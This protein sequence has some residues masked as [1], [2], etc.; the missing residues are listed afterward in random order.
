MSHNPNIIDYKEIRRLCE[1]SSRI[2]ERVVDDFLLGFAA[3]HHGLEKKMNLAFSRYRHVS[4]K[5]EKETVNL[6][7][8][9]FIMHRVFSEGGLIGKFL[10]NPS[11]DRFM[12]EERSY[13]IQQAQ[14]PWRFSFAE[15]IEEPE[16]DFYR[17]KDVFSR[18]DYLLFS[19]SISDLKES[20]DAWLWF[21][22]IG[23][24]GS[25]WQSYGPIGA[26]Q[27]FEHEDIFFFAS[28]K[29]PDV[30]DES[31][32]QKDIENDPIAYMMLLSGAAFPRTFHDKDE[33]IFLMAEHDLETLDTAGL[34]KG[35]KSEFDSGV[36]RFTHKM[37]G[38]HPHFAQ[39]F[40]DED[41][42]ILLFSS[43][44]E[45]GFLKLIEDFNAL[46]YS[47]PSIP[48]FHVRL[49]MIVTTEDILKK[50]IVLNEY[51]LL[52]PEKSDPVDAK[53]VEDLN[54]FVSIVLPEINAGRTPDIEGA[55][56]K[57]GVHIET[58]HDVVDM[59]KGKRNEIPDAGE[60]P[61][62]SKQDGE[63]G[64]QSLEED[65]T[66]ASFRV[67]YEKA[68]GIRKMEPWKSLYETDLFGVQMPGSDRIYFISVMGANGKYTAL[69]A[70]KG[71]EGLFRFIN[72]LENVD[73]LPMET[74]MTIPHLILSFTDR[75]DMDK[76]NLTAIKK[77]GLSFRGKGKWPKLEEVVPGY[78]P[79]F[80]EKETLEDLPVLLDQA[81]SVLS[82]SRDNPDLLFREG[83]SGD[84][85]LIRTPYEKSGLLRWKN[86]YVKPDPENGK[87]GYKITYRKDTCEKLSKLKVKPV[88]LLVDM[89]LLP[90][91]V[92]EKG[93][94]GY[95]PF[96]LLLVDKESG[97]IHGMNMLTP[98][99]DLSS[100]YESVPQKLLEEI[101][102]LGYRPEKIELRSDLLF[103][104]V[105]GAL[106]KSWC[107][108]VLVD[109]MPLMD[110]TI[111]S[112]F[113]N[114]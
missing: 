92:K 5:F 51:E 87:E 26:F 114:L 68:H 4:S 65:Q 98:E 105:E 88:T 110:E 95:F 64:R 90:A 66:S 71:Y 75:K 73:H 24:N 69:A 109:Q 78:I 13:L 48:Y 57:T 72:F 59:I 100:L 28:E 94:K 33:I 23:Y 104:L 79:A 111:E 102:K 6:F 74:L 46:G 12:G 70:Y 34:K 54:A 61:V 43:M 106:K 62:E 85:I 108:P 20:G 1:K 86:N 44:T 81:A 63:Q 9:Q 56:Q 21:N 37:F 113:E 50:K 67:I 31:E 7:K 11:L 35:F 96:M 93:K 49:Q 36:Y 47:F 27:S 16:K 107:M 76:E 19:P 41:E 101:S 32:V 45:M 97:M 39:V 58:A 40:F 29:N 15:I 52:F 89:V 3:R 8:S 80:P 99:P 84:E 42:K 14:V 103:G 38:E 91:P 83:D 30:E 22:L 55:A 53:A 77:S 2:T 82:W 60:H 18:E 112:F 17:M 10:K 25:C